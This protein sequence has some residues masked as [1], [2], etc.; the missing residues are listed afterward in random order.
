MLNLYYSALIA[1]L[2]FL[3]FTFVLLPLLT[4]LIFYIAYGL[5]SLFRHLQGRRYYW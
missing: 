5:V 4:S 3:F 1:V 2:A